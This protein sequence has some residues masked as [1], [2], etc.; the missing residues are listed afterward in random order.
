[1][2]KVFPSSD[3]QVRK[4]QVQTATGQTIRAVRDLYPLETQV[5]GYIDNKLQQ[6][7]IN[8]SKNDFIGFE[9]PKPPNRAS[10]ILEMLSAT[11]DQANK[12][13]SQSL[14]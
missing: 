14:V 11:E 2:V 1:M 10:M 12:R 8:L 3:G 4:C 7:K 5:E 13:K 9:D 6:E